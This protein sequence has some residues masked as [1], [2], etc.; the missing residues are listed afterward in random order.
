MSVTKNGVAT[1]ISSVEKRAI[2]I[3]CYAHALNL[4][5]G[6][7][8]KQS[9]LCCAALEVAIEICK[10]IKFSP[11]REAA[12]N[13]IK[14]QIT[15]ENSQSVSIRIFCPTRWTVHVNSIGSILENYTILSQLWEEYLEGKLDPDIKGRII[16]VKTLMLKFNVWF[17]LKLSERIL[18]ITDNLSMKTDPFGFSRLCYCSTY[19][20]YFAMHEDR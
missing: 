17:G 2:Y 4:A 3:H 12:F 6:Y 9:K 10:L 15:Q 14:G 8:M 20:N 18:K 5:V 19:R 13:F 16:R 7:T 1:Q 11:K